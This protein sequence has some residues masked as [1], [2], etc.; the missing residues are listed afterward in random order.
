MAAVIIMVTLR[1]ERGN[2][3]VFFFAK[4]ELIERFELF[5]LCKVLVSIKRGIVIE[6]TR[7]V[8]VRV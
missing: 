6:Y 8:S 3:I 5:Q 4:S 1:S 7:T 2:F